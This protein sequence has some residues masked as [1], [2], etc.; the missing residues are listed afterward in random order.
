[1]ECVGRAMAAALVVANN[2]IG[3]LYR[4]DTPRTRALRDEMTHIPVRRH[5]TGGTNGSGQ[6]TC[7]VVRQ[8][9]SRQ[10]T[11]ARASAYDKTVWWLPN[12]F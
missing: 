3:Y 7:Q 4:V 1:M 9:S 10:D 11:L 6:L 8:H 2:F 5:K 12:N